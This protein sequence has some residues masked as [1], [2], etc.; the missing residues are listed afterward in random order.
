MILSETFGKCFIFL[1]HKQHKKRREIVSAAGPQKGEKSKKPGLSFRVR[2]NL[3]CAEPGAG[4]VKEAKAKNGKASHLAV[5]CLL[6][7][8]DLNLRP[9][10][11]DLCT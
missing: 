5:L 10:G 4:P 11:F 8:Q 1:P 6:Y 3:R 9:L 2:C 7:G